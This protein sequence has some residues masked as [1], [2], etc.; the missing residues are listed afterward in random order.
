MKNVERMNGERWANNVETENGVI[1]YPLRNFV[2]RHPFLGVEKEK[3]NGKR[4]C[5]T[6]RTQ[7][8]G[9]GDDKKEPFP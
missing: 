7:Q 3:E 5:R 8:G 1:S 2:P 4:K 9:G 6:I